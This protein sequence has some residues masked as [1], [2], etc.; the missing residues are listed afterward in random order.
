[1]KSV[2]LDH[3]TQESVKDDAKEATLWLVNAVK[4]PGTQG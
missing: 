2:N 1:M 3:D 4:M